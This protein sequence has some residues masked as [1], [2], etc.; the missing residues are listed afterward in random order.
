MRLIVLFALI[1]GIAG[2]SAAYAAEDYKGK[3]ETGET[4]WIIIAKD[5]VIYCYKTATA[6]SGH[7]PTTGSGPDK[8][9]LSL[10]EG[11]GITLTKEIVAGADGHYWKLVY[12]HA[13]G[14]EY[15]AFV[16]SQK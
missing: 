15:N 14:K 9:V 5:Q 2:A 8:I 4:V 16:Y 13:N 11:K 6:C 7:E 1:A 3:F 10:K 12:R